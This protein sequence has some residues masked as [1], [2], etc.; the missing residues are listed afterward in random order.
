MDKVIILDVDGNKLGEKSPN[1]PFPEYVSGMTITV[2]SEETNKLDF[3]VFLTDKG[4][5]LEVK[6]FLQSLKGYNGGDR[7]YTLNVIPNKQ[8]GYCLH[9]DNETTFEEYSLSNLTEEYE[10]GGIHS[11]FFKRKFSKGGD[12]ISF[13]NDLID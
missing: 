4:D 13:Q 7:D 12:L 9:F 11:I 10:G 3:D 1:V 2:D 5:H 6:V 8:K